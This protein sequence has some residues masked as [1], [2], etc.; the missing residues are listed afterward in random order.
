MTSLLMHTV[1]HSTV[2]MHL[3]YICPLHGHEQMTIW[4]KLMLAQF[5][6]PNVHTTYILYI[7]TVT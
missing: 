5:C 6:L 3:I 1:A 4:K 7:H 2:E